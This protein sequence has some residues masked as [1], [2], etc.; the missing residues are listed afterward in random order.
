MAPANTGS[1]NNKSKAVIP[2]D[3]TNR[4]IRSRVIPAGRIL[5][6]VEIKFTAPRIE[7]TPAR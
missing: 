5:I 7:E 6:M 4:G 3:Q 2:T 1:D